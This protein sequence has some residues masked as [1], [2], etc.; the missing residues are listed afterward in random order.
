[1]ADPNKRNVGSIDESDGH[2]SFKSRP[3]VGQSKPYTSGS[4]AHG[5]HEKATRG[6]DPGETSGVSRSDSYKGRATG[7]KKDL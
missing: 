7:T 4:N 5:K 1:M 2:R 6:P 3:S